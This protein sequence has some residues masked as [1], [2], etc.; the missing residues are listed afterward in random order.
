LG[1]SIVRH[2]IQDLGGEISFASEQGVGTEATVKLPLVPI[3]PAK[4]GTLDLV[5]EVK[6]STEGKSFLLEGFDRY[7][8]LAETP[9]G[10]LSADI[11][12]SM[13]LKSSIHDMLTEW[14]GMQP[15]RTPVS[16]QI[17]ANVVVIMESGVQSLIQK[18]QSYGTGSGSLIA[19]VLCSTY[20]P[21]SADTLVG[22][23]RVFYIPQP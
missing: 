11:E 7:P 18:L 22:S 2:I 17:S 16:S 12:A 6:R 8:D 4:D 10:L 1:L 23:T 9:T 5:R 20:P 13:F 21:A 15:S 19:I 3:L 14:F